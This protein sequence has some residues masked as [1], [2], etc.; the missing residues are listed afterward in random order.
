[1]PISSTL[2]YYS[3][4]DFRPSQPLV[5]ELER[6]AGIKLN[7]RVSLRRHADALRSATGYLPPV[8]DD[9]GSGD[10]IPLGGFV[11]SRAMAAPIKMIYSS[12]RR[13]SKLRT[14][15]L[16]SPGDL[17]K[18]F[19]QLQQP[20]KQGH[21]LEYLAAID[22]HPAAHGARTNEARRRQ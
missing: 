19:L 8:R 18:R 20:R 10:H 14:K 4:R 16:A 13:G 6:S 11:P 12:S 5:P 1:M 17:A 7:V 15:P 3:R 21:E 9:P 2:V 22:R